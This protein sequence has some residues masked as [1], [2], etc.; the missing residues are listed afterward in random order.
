MKQPVEAREFY[1]LLGAALAAGAIGFALNRLN[2]ISRCMHEVRSMMLYIN[3]AMSSLTERDIQEITE[4]HTSKPLLVSGVRSRLKLL[5]LRQDVT[6]FSHTSLPPRD[7][8][9]T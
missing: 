2:E 8:G 7:C 4:L 5:H 3:S 1:Y 9:I 6:Q